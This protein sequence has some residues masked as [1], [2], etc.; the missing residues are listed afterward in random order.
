MALPVRRSSSP[1]A[2]VERWDP[3]RE[4]EELHTRT[5][6][7][8]ESLLA[9]TGAGN[10]DVWAPLVDIEETDDAWIV[11]AEVPGA[12]RKDVHVDVEGSEVTITGDIKERD[13]KG[14]LRRRARRTGSF[15]YRVS[16]P[17]E[18][19]PDAVDASLHDGVLTLR[20]PKP[21]R[22]RPH[23]VELTGD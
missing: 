8:M 19:D 18:L 17:G 20:V 6:Q 22:S 9:G 7:L 16:L 3:F 11:E 23:R 5:E 13:R 15:E 1:G 12:K 4:M 21:E 2:T 14:I 10:G